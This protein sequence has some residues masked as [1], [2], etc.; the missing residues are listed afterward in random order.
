VLT[1]LASY[2]NLDK[3]SGYV[4]HSSDVSAYAGQSVTVRFT[5]TETDKNGGTT[6]FVLDD[7]AL[8]TK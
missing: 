3:V 2:S 7:T 4:Q 1:T 6:S 5:G 8:N